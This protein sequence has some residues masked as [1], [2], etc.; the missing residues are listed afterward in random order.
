MSNPYL[1]VLCIQE[2]VS[3]FFS[4]YPRFRTLFP[5]VLMICS[6]ITLLLQR[7][8]YVKQCGFHNRHGGELLTFHWKYPGTCDELLRLVGS[9]TDSVMLNRS[10]MHLPDIIWR[11]CVCAI[12][13]F[14]LHAALTF[15]IAR[16]AA[17]QCHNLNP[18]YSITMDRHHQHL[19]R[20]V[21]D[22]AEPLQTEECLP[23][24]NVR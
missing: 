15:S 5:N 2:D 21:F 19:E 22:H 6:R 20:L 1:V 14:R 18:W 3:L 8:P 11:S 23:S 7:Q 17:E 16:R 12:R 4:N 24:P 9:A 10:K 13:P